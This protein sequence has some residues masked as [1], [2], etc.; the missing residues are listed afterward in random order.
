MEVANQDVPNKSGRTSRTSFFLRQNQN[1][2]NEL[3][4]I[5]LQMSKMVARN[6]V[7]VLAHILP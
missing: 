7:P 5:V 4:P 2:R 6:G 1:K 3:T